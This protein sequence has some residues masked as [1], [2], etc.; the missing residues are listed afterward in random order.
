MNADQS[1]DG[2][3]LFSAMKNLVNSELVKLGGE[4]IIYVVDMGPIYARLNSESEQHIAVYKHNVVRTHSDVNWQTHWL[5][6][7]MII[8]SLFNLDTAEQLINRYDTDGDLYL[9]KM[10]F[11]SIPIEQDAALDLMIRKDNTRTDSIISDNILDEEDE[12]DMVW[13]REDGFINDLRIHSGDLQNYSLV[14]HV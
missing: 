4:D 6:S 3:E 2:P 10:E 1:L 11:Y 5:G 7:W 14:E 9:G 8:L 12:N 13:G